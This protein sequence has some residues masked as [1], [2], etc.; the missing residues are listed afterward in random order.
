M[1]H[2]NQSASE[3]LVKCSERRTLHAGKGAVL[4]PHLRRASALPSSLITILQPSGLQP[5]CT[6]ASPGQLLSD[7]RPSSPPAKCGALGSTETPR[8]YWCR[9]RT[10]SFHHWGE[11]PK[12]PSPLDTP[13]SAQRRGYVTEERGKQVY[14]TSFFMKH[15]SSWHRGKLR[16]WA[17]PSPPA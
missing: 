2:W 8:W 12:I 6:T 11:E 1:V 3:T 13:L 7:A 14:P 9:S 17:P 15:Q 4:H 5:G 10:P 16:H